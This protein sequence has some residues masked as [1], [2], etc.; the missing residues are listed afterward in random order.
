MRTTS[1]NVIF[2]RVRQ[3]YRPTWVISWSRQGY[4]NASY[5]I[6]HTGRQPAMQRPTAVPRIP[7]SASGV[8]T[9]RSGPNRSRRPAVA[10]KT[11]PA[12]PTSSPITMTEGS[13][14]TSSWKQSLIAS[15]IDRSATCPT[16]L[17][18]IGTDRRGRID[19]RMRE[20]QA[21]VRG[22]LRFGSR[23]PRAHHVRR[24]GPDRRGEIVVEDPR[25]AEVALEPAD[26]LTP[27]LL[28]DT[29]EIDVRT[30]IVGRRMRRQTIGAGLDERR[31]L[32]RTGNANALARR[33][34]A[35]E[36]IGA[37]HANAGHPVADG[38]VDERLRVR[39]L[40][41]RRGDRPPVVVAE[42]HER[43]A[44]DGSEI[45]A[46][47]ERPL[48]RGAVTEEGNRTGTLPL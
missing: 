8:S 14:S 44:H 20:E 11:P 47:V 4:E 42:Q 15:T 5:C 36:D 16:Q 28:F 41:D 7:A 29:L 46:L 38:F 22:R 26:A 23:D 34:V 1:G 17:L 33:L 12:R 37:V 32:A 24:F 10:R 40:L 19:V 3:R 9:Q 48:G 6:S 35:R 43:R 2:P 45:G 30:R 13:R 18:Q 39:L 27:L 21:D 25:T 31:P